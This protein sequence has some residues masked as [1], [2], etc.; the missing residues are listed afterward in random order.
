MHNICT[1]I[2]LREYPKTFKWEGLK[3]WNIGLIKI[4]KFCIILVHPIG[5]DGGYFVYL[6]YR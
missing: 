4:R 2:V 1:E 6:V 3:K 5:M